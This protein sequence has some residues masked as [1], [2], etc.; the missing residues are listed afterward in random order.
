[1]MAIQTGIFAISNKLL[2]HGDINI[3]IQDCKGNTA[4]IYAIFSGKKSSSGNL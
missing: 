1:M 2:K 4:L 3:N